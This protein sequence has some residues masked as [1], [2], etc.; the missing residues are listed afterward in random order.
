M[1]SRQP[2]GGLRLLNHMHRPPFLLWEVLDCQGLAHMMEKISHYFAQSNGR[3]RIVIVIQLIRQRRLSQPKR[4]RRANSIGDEHE[5]RRRGT[6]PH[7]EETSEMSLPAVPPLGRLVK[8]IFWVYKHGRNA[9]GNR[10]VL[11]PI[12]QQVL[13][14]SLPA[15]DID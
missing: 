13:T 1:P 5:P 4:K 7:A 9:A 10:V 2:S 6:L 8:G 3:I 15:L 11:C 14:P 12:T